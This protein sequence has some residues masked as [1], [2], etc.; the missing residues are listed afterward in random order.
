MRERVDEAFKSVRRDWRFAAL[1]TALL[2]VTLGAATAM[3]SAVH[4]V[5]LRPLGLAHQDRLVVAWKQDLR[6][7][8]PIIEVAHGEAADWRARSRSFDDVAVFGSVNWTLTVA[9]REKTDS[10]SMSAV[11]STFFKVVGVGALVGRTLGASDEG[12]R[13]PGAA[14]ISY[15]LW[16]RRFARDPDIL[17]RTLTAVDPAAAPRLI[18]IV[19]VMPPD[20]DFP[21]HVDVWLPAAPVLRSAGTAYT[22]GDEVS[23]F[24]WLGV[25]YAIGRLRD[26]VSVDDAAREVTH[27]MRTAD[28]QGGPEAAERVVLVPVTDFLIGPAQPVL[29]TLLA[30]TALLLLVGC[31]NVSALQVSRAARRHR[32]LAI[33]M[34]V[35]ASRAHL[36]GL[37]LLETLLVTLAAVAGAAAVTW[38]LQRMLVHIAPIDVPRLG[39]IAS[40]D[41]RVF[42]FG[43]VAVFASVLLSASWPVLAVSRIDA[44]TVLAHAG[45]STPDPGGRR[46]Q[47]AV[48]AA[49]VALA[50]LLLAGTGLFFRSIRALDHTVLGFSPDRLVAVPV[51]AAM[52]DLPTW[53][54][55]LDRL[56]EQLAATPGV[57]AVG[58]LYRRPLLGPIGLDNQPI[59]PGQTPA[60][61][62]TWGLNPHLNIET[63]TPGLFDAMGI[64]IVRG[65]GFTNAD[66][67]TAPGVVV[68]SKGAARR[69]WPGRDPI[70]QRLRDMS[71][72]V[73]RESSAWQTV[74]GVAE[75]VRYR[76]LTDV[77]LDLYVPA[78]QSTERVQYL[79]VRTTD[80]AAQVTRLVRAASSRIDQRFAIGDAA[81]MS[82]VV[83]TE[84]A[85]WRFIFRIFVAFAT[86]AAV[87]AAIGQATMIA[88]A[89]ATR[90][91][92]LALRSALGADRRQLRTAVIRDGFWPITVGVTGGLLATIA[93][94]PAI[95][96]VL[97]GVEPRDPLSL[98]AAA[99]LAT[100]VGTMA[101]WWSARRASAVDPASA[102]RSE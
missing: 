101:C 38:G 31:A 64:R 76:G 60:D 44:T 73:A 36:V 9:G 85:P 63:T 12:G 77:R 16:T 89:V 81:A 93:I 14:V 15:D 25:F 53:N 43:A 51:S 47:R 98:A 40:L 2:A 26:S 91:R 50:F 79:M 88:L 42:A 65:R 17:R 30:G 24:R 84:S 41:P 59:Y 57:Q 102:L 92:E 68:V 55:R 45:A 8:L 21:R 37:V 90:R 100:S 56:E 13:Q 70:G 5:L 19:G 20:F 10:L 23:A 28:Q 82:D 11:S 52:S 87:L 96:S 95:A 29:W 48:V 80:S 3:F 86:L 6:R 94:G 69:L 62:S 4:A 74:V 75:D 99:A 67:T 66:T 78:A 39:D 18:S 32:A 97:I 7:A 33:R 54:Q 58:A 49:Q 46:F 71:Y 27:V 72:R 83:A 1:A 22:G 61:P 35:G 34:A